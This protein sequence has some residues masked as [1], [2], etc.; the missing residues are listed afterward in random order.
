[1]NTHND[2]GLVMTNTRQREER[3][4]QLAAVNSAA[5]STGRKSTAPTEKAK[6][7]HTGSPP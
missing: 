2:E 7:G 1:M 6:L 5:S 4:E 3:R